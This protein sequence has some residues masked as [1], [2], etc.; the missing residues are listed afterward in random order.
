MQDICQANLQKYGIDCKTFLF[1]SLPLPFRDNEFEAI[2]CFETI[3]HMPEPKNFIKELARVLKPNGELLL[4]TPNTLWEP[5]HWLVA[6]LNLH[7]SEG[8]HRFLSRGFILQIAK[9]AGFLLDKEKT[10]VLITFGP[11][12]LNRFS[13]FLERVLPECVLRLLALRRIFVLR[14]ISDA[15]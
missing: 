9:E 2:L 1:K 15:I 6:I 12:F 10:T 7:H 5:G 13:K 14:R 4:T 3:E 11:K 8:P